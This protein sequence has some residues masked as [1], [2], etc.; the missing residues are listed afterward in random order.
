MKC[1]WC[2]NTVVEKV[3]EHIIPEPLGC[4]EDFLLQNKEICGRCNNNLGHLDQALIDEFDIFAFKNGIPRKKGKKPIINNRGNMVGK[5]IYDEKVIFLNMD[6]TPFLT[7]FG[8]KVSS[9]GNSKRAVNASLSSDGSIAKVN[10]KLNC[11]SSPKFFRALHKIAFESLVFSVGVEEGLNPRYD[12]IREYVLHGQ[13]TREVLFTTTDDGFYKNEFY[14]LEKTK[15][16]EYLSLF[17]LAHFEFGVDLSSNMDLIKV[18]KKRIESGN[19]YK[20]FTLI[21]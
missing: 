3:V 6:N 20:E 1:I 4:P 2:K 17:R 14:G 5:Y 10:F 18:I 16:D 15:N 13:G 21:G 12:S 19:E 9:Y 11:F 7:Q 8:D